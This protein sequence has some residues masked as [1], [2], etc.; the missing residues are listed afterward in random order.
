[1]ISRVIRAGTYYVR[2]EAQETLRN[3]YALRYAVSEPDSGV[4]SLVDY[5]APLDG[6]D[7]PG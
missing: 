3:D 1:M 2:V 5:P 4:G 7:L 6:P